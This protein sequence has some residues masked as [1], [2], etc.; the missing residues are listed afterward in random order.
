MALLEE[1]MAQMHSQQA[2]P[3]RAPAAQNT[4]SPDA[5]WITLYPIYIDARKRYRKGA[6]RVPCEK[7]V[8]CPQS[9]HMAN[10]AQFLGFE[11]AHEPQHTHPQDWENPGRVKVH[12]YGPGHMPLKADLPTRTSLLTGR[13]LYMRIGEMLQMRL[14]GVP[15]SAP[16]HA[17]GLAA[18]R[19][20]A[21]RAMSGVP[22]EVLPPHSPALAGGLLNMDIG[23]AM[24]GEALQGMGPLGSMLGSMGIGEDEPEEPEA[25]RQQPALGRRQR[26]RVVRISR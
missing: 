20:R 25:P 1:M 7:A 21:R 26:K 17:R 22:T 14:G 13:A 11:V 18:V 10:A 12:F 9:L 5:S 6:R 16:A 2:E 8:R 19:A 23:K 3:A 15:P 24:G 4:R